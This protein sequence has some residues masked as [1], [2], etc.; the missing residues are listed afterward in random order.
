MVKLVSGNGECAVRTNEFRFAA[1]SPLS[2]NQWLDRFQAL[3]VKTLPRSG[4]VQS[5]YFPL[6]R[7]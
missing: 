1:R 2:A 7:W 3:V 4:L 5:L 6:E